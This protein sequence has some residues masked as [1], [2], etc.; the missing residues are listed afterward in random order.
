MA[1]TKR[2]RK[3]KHR[4][5]QGG[6]VETNRSRPRSRA[7]ARAQYRAQPQNRVQQPPTWTGSIIKAAVISA[8]VG[9]SMILFGMR[10]PPQAIGLSVFMLVF[11]IPMGYYIDRFFYNRRETKRV[12]E[13]REKK[14][15]RGR[16]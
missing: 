1:Q 3:R 10:T 12:A 5:T 13:L 16:H 4:G 9:G 15:A 11:Y 14:Q 6:K 8:L 7:E 2:K